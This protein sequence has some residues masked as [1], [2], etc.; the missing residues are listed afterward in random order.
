MTSF[1]PYQILGLG[2]TAPSASVKSAYRKRVQT[3]HPDRG[4]DQ[5]EFVAI[6][7]A[8]GVLSDP[9]A[10][11]LF[12]ETGL[13]DDDGLRS[14][15]QD[16]T[17]I[18]ADMFDAAVQTAIEGGLKL[19]TVNFVALMTTSVEKSAAEATAQAKKIDAEIKAITSLR[20]RIRRN[21]ENS[22]LFVE[23]LDAQIQDKINQ[24]A[25]ARRR[26]FI[27]E[28]AIVELG[29]YQSEVELI[30]ALQTPG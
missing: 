13:V 12:D 5:E 29:N 20:G 15:R 10:R 21:D 26:A 2:R 6:V 1:D 23:R 22:N 7:K 16:V 9:D 24:H 14:Y 27:L 17:M 8:F 30:S 3:A 19:A 18:L 4:G 28:T 25:A 11:R